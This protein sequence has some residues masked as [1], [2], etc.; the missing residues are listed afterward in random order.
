MA[1]EAVEEIE[2]IIEEIIEEEE[3][4]HEESAH[5]S[6]VPAF[7]HSSPEESVRANVLTL[8]IFFFTVT[9]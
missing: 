4:E 9:N 8:S 6:S 5:T 3:E 1:D 2:E 7:D